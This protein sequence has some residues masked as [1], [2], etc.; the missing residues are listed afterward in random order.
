MSRLNVYAVFYLNLMFSSL[1]VED[2]PTVIKKCYWPLLEL[3]A[4][5]YPLALQ[6]S[7]VTL[8]AIQE[9]DPAWIERLKTLLAEKKCELVG[10][11]YSHI[12]APL[13]PADV[14]RYNQ[15]LGR[16]IYR[17]MLNAEPEV[18]TVTEMVYSSGI[19]EHYADAGYKA[20]MM[21][22]NNPRQYHPE[23]DKSWR[24]H[25]QRVNTAS[26]REV[27][28]L[29]MDTI[30]FQKFQRYTHGELDMDGYMSYLLDQK[31]KSL[32]QGSLCIYASDA[33]VFDFRPGRYSTEG[34]VHGEGEWSRI[35]ALLD[36]LS[37]HSEF[38]LALP[39]EILAM[40]RS[41]LSDNL[42]QLQSP[43]QPIPVKK[44]E[45]YNL[46]RWSVTGRDSI[47][48]N[49]LCY[50]IYEL[51]RPHP[52]SPLWKDLCYAWGSDFRTHIGEERFAACC[53]LLDDLVRKAE[54]LGPRREPRVQTGGAIKVSREGNLLHCERGKLNVTLNIRRGLAIDSLV[55][56]DISSRP[57]VRTLPH[58]YYEDVTLAADFYSGNTT[59]DIPAT[60]RVT[61][62]GPADVTIDEKN[63]RITGVVKTPAGDIMKTITLLPDTN[64]LRIEYDFDLALKYPLSFRTGIVAMNP[65]AFERDSLFYRCHNGGREAEKFLLKD[66]VNISPDPLSLLVSART[67]L[68]NT[69]GVF[70]MGDASKYIRIRTEPSELAT[71][72]I[73]TYRRAGETFFYRVAQTLAEVDDT[74]KVRRDTPVPHFKFGMEISAVRER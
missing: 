70:D 12:I 58:G 62:L 27:A 37:Q 44:Q 28:L 64:S 32:Q 72:P 24:Y 69:T 10:D 38:S 39:S 25:R 59:V 73:L 45:K 56:S 7:G 43:E 21:E 63:G 55:F 54:A 41:D 31:Q 26:G 36:A 2:R 22:W 8:E 52:E 15:K 71:V 50:R 29:W 67:A 3:I 51:L 57:L 42:L 33:E 16:D 6:P 35:R 34:A 17:K 19:V 40:P 61:D 1:S 4:D 14:N 66:V 13:A 11:G 60:Q 20:L 49:T 74:G 65:E 53:A 46:T 30:A 68:G 47:G 18:A 23:W 48:I 9:L 5:G